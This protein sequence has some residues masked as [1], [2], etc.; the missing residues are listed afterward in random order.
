MAGVCEYAADAAASNI[1]V[2]NE[3]TGRDLNMVIY[4]RGH[5]VCRSFL[6]ISLESQAVTTE[7]CRSVLRDIQ[8]YL[9]CSAET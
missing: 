4:S 7:R 3:G 6:F 8:G 9:V 1:E 2:I 5:S